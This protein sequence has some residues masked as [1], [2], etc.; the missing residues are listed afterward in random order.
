MKKIILISIVVAM[1]MSFTACMKK[2]EVKDEI[3]FKSYIEDTVPERVAEEETTT[4]ETTP[5]ETEAAVDNPLMTD[6]VRAFIDAVKAEAP[7][8]GDF[9][10]KSSSIPVAMAFNQEADLMG[11][12]QITTAYMEIG[13][14]SFDQF[15]VS[16]DSLGSPMDIIITDGKYYMV[17]AEEKTAIY[18][19]MS[20]EEAA[21][22]NESMT[23][24]VKASFDASAATYETGEAEFKDA[25]YYYEKIATDEMG[26][27]E[28]YADPATKELKYLVSQGV[29]M[30][31]LFVTDE[32]DASKLEIPA[33]YTLIDM[34]EM[35]G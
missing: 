9:L 33:D 10:E 29:T 3:T 14:A 11:D 13:M 26:E 4:A 19:A 5:E 20:D 30:E 25:T 17:S 2:P 15:Y 23:A 28:V 12:G 18:M 7:V 16:T 32:I 24:S 6:E 21:E 1:M 34:A 27:I 31:V 35:M 22:M 8:Y